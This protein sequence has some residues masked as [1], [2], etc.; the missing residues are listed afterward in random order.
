[1]LHAFSLFIYK[2]QLPQSPPSFTVLPQNG[3]RFLGGRE[4]V[5]V[6]LRPEGKIGSR[7]GRFHGFG[8]LGRKKTYQGWFYFF[9]EGLGLTDRG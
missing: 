3:T 8:V 9:A 6:F 1:M 2:R 5:D 4:V 7:R